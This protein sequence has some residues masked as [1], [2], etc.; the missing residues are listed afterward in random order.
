MVVPLF[1]ETGL[2]AML[3]EGGGAI[4]PLDPGIRCMADVGAT[5]AAVGMVAE[6][7]TGVAG[8]GACVIAEDLLAVAVVG[9]GPAPALVVIQPFLGTDL[10]GVEEMQDYGTAVRMQFLPA[11]LGGNGKPNQ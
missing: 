6:A 1:S 2:V 11:D 4:V 7:Y 10:A 9:R 3:I 8:D 5:D